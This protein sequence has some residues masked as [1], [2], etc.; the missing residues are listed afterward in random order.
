LRSNGRVE[1]RTLADGTVKEYRYGSRARSAP[2]ERTVAAVV[3][4]WHRSVEW[5]QLRPRTQ[6]NYVYYLQPLHHAMKLVAVAKLKRSHLMA[7][8]DEIA[9]SRGHGAA[10]TFCRAVSAF[11]SW[12]LDR[13]YIDASPATKLGTK[14]RRG[15]LPAWRDDQAQLAMMPGELPEPYRRIVVLAYHTGQRRGDL[16]RLRWSDYDGNVIRLTQEKTDE[17]LEIPVYQMPGFKAEL[18]A[19]KAERTTMT[20]LEHLGRPWAVGYVSARLPKYL[21][22][23]GLPRGL[24]LHGL[25][26]LT[27]IRLAEAGCT[28]HE[29]AA[30][31]GHRTLAMVQ[32]YT[33]GVSQR[34]LADVA[35]LRLGKNKTRKKI[36]KYNEISS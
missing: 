4:A 3:A 25:R 29:I 16:C 24:N 28:P 21:E 10:L 32:E 23:I 1:R 17:P 35:V 15:S 13:D 18:D 33:R 19:W 14:L 11:F 7:I 8:R 20:I 36:K 5:T 22:Q 9:M 30:I 2:S 34:N 6:E 12:A 31:T 27:A 26:R